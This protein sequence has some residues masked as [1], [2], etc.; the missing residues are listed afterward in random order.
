MADADAGLAEPRDLLRVEMDAMR[1]P[2]ALRH[3]ARVLEQIDGAQAVHLQAEALLVRG[4]A[5]MGVELAI[6][7]LGERGAVAHQPLVDRERRAG[8][9]RDAD[10]RAGLRVME[11]LQHALAVGEDRV[12]VLHD[13]VGRQ[14]AVLLA[15]GSSSRA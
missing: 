12:L 15:T 10:L 9:E 4:L 6:V 3:P 11:Q 5:E 14:A 8:R 1:E 13:A 7:A 2:G